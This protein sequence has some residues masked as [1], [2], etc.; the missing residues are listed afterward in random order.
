MFPGGTLNGTYNGNGPGGIASQVAYIDNYDCGTPGQ[1]TCSNYGTAFG[2]F[3]TTNQADPNNGALSIY[4][5]IGSG[6]SGTTGGKSGLVRI[7]VGYVGTNNTTP[8][9][10]NPQLTTFGR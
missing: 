8:A 5:V 2:R 9:E 6:T 4:Y 7:S 1:T 10:T 3:E